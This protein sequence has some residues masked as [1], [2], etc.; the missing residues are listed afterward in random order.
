MRLPRINFP[1]RFILAAV[2]PLVVIAVLPAVGQR[3]L[4]T[5][6]YEGEN[7]ATSGKATVS[8]GSVTAQ[9]MSGFGTSWSGNAQLFWGG[10]QPGAVL[11]LSLDVASAGEYRI[12]LHMTKAPD[13]G[14]LKIQVDGKTTAVT[15]DGYAPSVMPSGPIN[16]GE[17]NLTA[18][19]H[20]LNLL[21]TGKHQSSTGFLVGI[22]LVLLTPMQ[23]PASSGGV[24]SSEPV[25]PTLGHW[26]S[27]GPTRVAAPADAS[28]GLGPYNASGRLNSIAISASD[29]AIYVASPGEL[30]NGGSGVWK[31]K[32]SGQ[33]WQPIADGLPT[34]AVSAVALAPLPRRGV[35][36]RPS[37]R[38]FIVT[39][40]NAVFRS[41]DAGTTWTST[42]IKASGDFHV[43]RNTRDGDLT[44]LLVNPQK[45][46]VMYLTA[47]EGVWRSEDAGINWN[48]SL[49]AA[50]WATDL[51]MDPRDP[52]KLYAAIRGQGIYKTSDGGVS[53]NASWNHLTTAPLLS[54][55][56]STGHRILLAISHPNA[57]LA[58]T[59]YAVYPYALTTKPGETVRFIV[60]RSA[61]GGAS[62]E[63]KFVCGPVN[64]DTCNFWIMGADPAD[65]ENV[66]LGGPS[67]FVSSDGATKFVRVPSG[68][69]NDRQPASPHGDY[70]GLAFDPQDPKIIYV[71]S[72]GGIYRSSDHG[73]TGTWT[74]IGEGIKNVEAYDIARSL[75]TPNLLIAGTQDNGTISYDGQLVWDHPYPLAPYGGDGATVAI[76]PQSD[77]VWITMG[78]FQDSLQFSQD[79]GKNFV[80]FANGLPKTGGGPGEV[81][82][83]TYNSFFYFHFH[84][85]T[86][87]TLLA[88]CR[89]LW[90]T[91]T[92]TPPGDWKPIFAPAGW[93]VRSAVNPITDMYYAG[94]GDGD[95]RIYAG[96]SGNNWQEVF[97]HPGSLGVSDLEVDPGDGRILYSSFAKPTTIERDC[98]AGSNSGRIFLLSRSPSR[99][100]SAPTSTNMT[101]TNITSNLPAGLCVTTLAVGPRSQSS[102]ILYAGTQKGVYR[103]RLDRTVPGATWQWVS[104]NNGMP[105]A[106]VRDLEINV[107]TNHIYAATYGRGVFEFIPGPLSVP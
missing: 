46:S 57:G 25:L 19:G 13:Y 81:Y 5:R 86:P 76:S 59:V 32:D 1:A 75:T 21:I 44:V 83:A 45:P 60:Y 95:G 52:L 9:T 15:F 42:S 38:V 90:R 40:D 71:A 48:L 12:E 29:H 27:L 85:S 107:D 11:D 10:G 66:Y 41:D 36:L 16:I 17:F 54:T 63:R 2:M 78:Q 82:C 31:T 67:F 28:Q 39:A 65:T 87:T 23:N 53:G 92:L 94:T 70:H 8:G 3:R 74:F 93:V 106:D 96:P 6:V 84:P 37:Q 97:H 20:K 43:R 79:G 61:T 101:A 30:G 77:Q 102:L 55:N 18:G 4:T 24:V 73:K 35:V 80:P 88:S 7:L 14:Q 58:E 98:N 34:L 64:A 99:S 51:V 91:T 62:W 100:I 26:V 33:H 22:D 50:A 104:L 56:I 89:K 69:S 47:D 49:N 103:G 68:T 72:D 105:A